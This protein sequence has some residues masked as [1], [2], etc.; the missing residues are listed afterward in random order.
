MTEPQTAS[1]RSSLFARKGEAAPSPAVAYVSVRQLQG[2]PERRAEGPD[3][4]ERQRQRRQER[5]SFDGPDRRGPD[6]RGSSDRRHF[7]PASGLAFGQQRV[8]WV[9]PER[10]ADASEET[11]TEDDVRQVPSFLS[12]LIQRHGVAKAPPA[13]PAPERMVASRPGAAAASPATPR[14]EREPAALDRPAMPARQAPTMIDP[15]RYLSSGRSRRQRV[16]APQPGAEPAA[17]WPAQ[18]LEH[19]ERHKLTMRL[20][21]EHY[22]QF[23]Q[24]VARSG[25]TQQSI[26]AAAIAA[27]LEDAP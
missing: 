23:M 18:Q 16:A 25:R 19:G 14:P 27:F 12:S 21:H 17:P 5:G 15:E 11:T 24:F 3:R 4:R 8:A 20:A 10:P 22:Q 6:Q 7:T 9:D 1:P 13:A 2:K 26:L